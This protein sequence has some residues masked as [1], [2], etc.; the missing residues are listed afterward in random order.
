MVRMIAEL[1]G[2]AGVL[3]IS[4]TVVEEK[5]Y[6]E[7][8]PI[9]GH[10]GHISRG[11]PIAQLSAVVEIPCASTRTYIKLPFFHLRAVGTPSERHR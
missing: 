2:S 4:H 7:R 10:S 9:G 5:P 6:P 11:N 3:E 1:R 8:A